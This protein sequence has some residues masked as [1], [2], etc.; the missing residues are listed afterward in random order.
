MKACPEPWTQVYS[1]KRVG[2]L[3]HVSR[4]LRGSTMSSGPRYMLSPIPKPAEQPGS[5]E[6]GT[7]VKRFST[8]TPW[9]FAY[10]R[11]TSC[12][13]EWHAASRNP[14]A[15][16]TLRSISGTSR[17]GSVDFSTSARRPRM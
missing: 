13:S 2:R 9:R 7:Y 15:S 10:V 6:R 3:E 8:V 5:F 14:P 16:C 17:A 4:R 11:P 12:M 1:R